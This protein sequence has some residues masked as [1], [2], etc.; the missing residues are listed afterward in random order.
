MPVEAAI[1]AKNEFIEISVDVLAAQAVICAEAPAFHQRESP[2]NP[3]QDYV[4]C[5]LADYACVVPIASQS[6][7]VRVSICNQRV[8]RFTFSFTKASIYSAELSAI[9]ASRMLPVRLSRYFSFFPRV[10]YSFLSLSIT[11]TAP[12][13][14]ILPALPLSR[15]ASPSL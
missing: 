5:H 11:S 2:I 10:F 4:S 3:R 15:N 12:M 8:P 9:I 14:R 7:I 6:Q 1:I 13:T